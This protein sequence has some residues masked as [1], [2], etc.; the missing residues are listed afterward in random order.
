MARFFLQSLIIVILASVFELLLP[1]WSVAV[2][3]AIG[4]FMFRSNANFLAGFLSIALLWAIT[5][6]IIDITAASKLTER[7]AAVFMMPKMFLF[8]LT[9]L[10]GGL[11]GGFAALAGSAL[12]KPKR[13]YH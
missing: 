4:G 2:A 8:V 7:V 9:A 1:W 12:R 5:S 11:V 3:A 10:L 6:L 13:N